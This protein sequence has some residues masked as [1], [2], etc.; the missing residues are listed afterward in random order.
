MFEKFGLQWMQMNANLGGEKKVSN[1][2]GG[3]LRD[4]PF[5]FNPLF[6]NH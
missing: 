4:Q 3:R 1:L 6:K 2:S 5:S